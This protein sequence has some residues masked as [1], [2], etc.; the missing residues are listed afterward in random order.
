MPSAFICLGKY[1]HTIFQKKILGLSK[2]IGV[3]ESPYLVM[4]N[5]SVPSISLEALGLP[6]QNSHVARIPIIKAKRNQTFA[7]WFR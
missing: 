6:R 7:A 4:G 5:L 2:A 3:F 1:F